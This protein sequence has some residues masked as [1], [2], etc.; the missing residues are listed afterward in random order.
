MV[1]YLLLSPGGGGTKCSFTVKVFPKEVTT[2][3]H[4]NVTLYCMTSGDEDISSM[5]WHHNDS[6]EVGSGPILY[7]TGVDSTDNGTYTCSV[8][9]DNGETSSDTSSLVVLSEFSHAQ[10]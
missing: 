8:T 4:T 3:V 9:N 1:L 7:I 10:H 6:I 5:K 2:I